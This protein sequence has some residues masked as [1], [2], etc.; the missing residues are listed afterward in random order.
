MGK[1]AILIPSYKPKNYLIECL[2]SIE[3]QNI[4]KS[5]F[6]VYLALNGSTDNDFY[7]VQKT[8]KNYSFNY[9]IFNLKI[10]GVS[11]A[12][13]YLIDHSTEDFIAFLDDDDV[14]S[15]N[16]LQSL[17]KNTTEDNMCISNV[18]NFSKSTIDTR[19]NYMGLSFKKSR[20]LESSKIRSRK[21]FSSACAKMLH[22]KMI[23]SIRFDQKLNSGED[24]FF[25]AEISCNIQKICKSEESAIY[26]VRERIGSATRQKINKKNEIKRI[27]YLLKK[28]FS[29]LIQ[30]KYDSGFILTRIL[31]TIK[32]S[33]KL[34]KNKNKVKN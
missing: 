18:L 22:R 2:D 1:I 20:Q 31:A 6:K 15:S 28:Y 19:A 16:Y 17:K 29:L 3:N 8:L 25:M 7:F 26:F 5:E 9:T 14:I 32:H 21:F 30:K 33:K 34:F 27:I 10:A 23:G 24:S 13:N 12:R 11:N 4:C